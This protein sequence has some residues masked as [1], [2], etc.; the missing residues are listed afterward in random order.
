MLRWDGDHST[1]LAFNASRVAV[2]TMPVGSMWSKNPI[3]TTLWERE[4]PS[5]S[6]VCEESEA[7]KQSQIYGGKPGDCR[8]SGFSNYGPL[9]PN[10]EI[11]DHVAIPT[12]LTPGRYVLQWRWDCEESDQVWASCSDVTIE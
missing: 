4:G 10:L 3:P 1:Q 5:F 6:P 8:C 9:L 11:V 2:G 7:C 12:S